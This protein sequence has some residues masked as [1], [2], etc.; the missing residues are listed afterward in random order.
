MRPGRVKESVLRRSVLRQLHMKGPFGSPAYG[1]DAGVFALGHHA[2]S[3]AEA[4]EGRDPVYGGGYGAVSV[5][6]VEGWTLAAWRTVCGAVNALAAAGAVPESIA[7]TILMPEHTEEP[8]LKELMRQ[9]DGGCR[10]AGMYCAAV[11]TAVSPCVTD[12]VLSAAAIG[13]FGGSETE[14]FSGA[15]SGRT[16]MDRPER[17]GSGRPAT[18][19]PPR[20]SPDDP[21]AAGLDVVA[22]GAV[23]RE[24]TAMLA[25]EE[26][27]ALSGRYPSFFIEEAKH[28]FDDGAMGAAADIG[29]AHGAV[30][31]HAAG[32]GGIFAALWEMASA[33][34]TGLDIELKRIP[35]R[36]H[37]VEVCEFFRLNPYML[38]SGGTLLMAGENGERMVSALRRQ[39]FA[40]AVIGH[41]TDN[42]D[43]IVRY[44]DEIRYLEPPK[45]DAYYA[46]H[47]PG[48]ETGAAV[49]LQK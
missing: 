33:G 43:K 16:D 28:L 22:A 30:C 44:D 38:R 46:V 3:L 8:R 29:R 32:E 34:R 2:A 14:G 25:C 26:E 37:T 12:L 20:L 9:I 10:Q 19:L 13:I 4:G 7:L 48:T 17:T 11:H 5:S 24:G 18:L 1:E 45:E 35:I 49:P 39:G 21:L 36:Q 40:A 41:T 27:K 6:P 47:R 31:V 15:D 42:N 23:A